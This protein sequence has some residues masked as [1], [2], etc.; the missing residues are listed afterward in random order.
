MQHTGQDVLDRLR[1]RTLYGDDRYWDV[2]SFLSRT[3]EI[4]A[5]RPL[6]DSAVEYTTFDGCIIRAVFVD[7]R[8]MSSPMSYWNGY[9]NVPSHFESRAFLDMVDYATLE[10]V[11]PHVP[12]EFTF[13]STRDRRV[14]WDHNHYNDQSLSEPMRENTYVTGPVQILEEG[15]SVVRAIRQHEYGVRRAQTMQTIEEELMQT[16]WAPSRVARMLEHGY[17]EITA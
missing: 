2:S 13:G 15:L 12:V 16:A 1:D 4:I 5:V 6:T 14:G 10:A 17:L 3:P 7:V 8:Y 9:V 11:L